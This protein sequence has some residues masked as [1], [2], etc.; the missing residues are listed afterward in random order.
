MEG[1]DLGAI[2]SEAVESSVTLDWTMEILLVSDRTEEST[3]SL[4]ELKF[5]NTSPKETEFRLTS[6][7]TGSRL[8]GGSLSLSL[9]SQNISGRESVLSRTSLNAAKISSRCLITLHLRWDT[10]P[11]SLSACSQLYLLSYKAEMSKRAEMTFLRL[12]LSPLRW[13][14]SSNNHRLRL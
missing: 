12:S 13:Q 7:E 2:L 9:A 3:C 1:W 6:S 8:R 11:A 14:A 5:V 10:S 4:R